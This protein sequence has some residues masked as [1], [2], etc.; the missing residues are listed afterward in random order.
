MNLAGAG[1]RLNL[2]TVILFPFFIF[3]TI[4]KSFLSGR[5]I[6]AFVEAGLRWN[7][8]ACRTYL[9]ESHKVGT[10][11]TS[12]RGPVYPE[13]LTAALARPAF[14]ITICP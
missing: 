2:N 8:P 1:T 4:L 7:I 12:D 13:Y 9:I 6:T 11:Q 5:L 10:R 3:T 14:A